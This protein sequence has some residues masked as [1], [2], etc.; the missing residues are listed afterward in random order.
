MKLW[1][2][3]LGLALVFAGVDA[4]ARRLGGGG[5]FGKQSGNVT[6]RQAPVTPPQNVSN[7]AG[8]PATA[9][10]AARSRKPGFSTVE[11]M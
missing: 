2:L 3:V 7:A 11:L 5:S 9:G 1:T 4:D 8:K 6:N 10:A